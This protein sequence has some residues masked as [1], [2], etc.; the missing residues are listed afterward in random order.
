[1]CVSMFDSLRKTIDCEFAHH[2]QPMKFLN[3]E[4]NKKITDLL[5]AFQQRI[6]ANSKFKFEFKFKF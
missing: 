5:S 4:G 6:K 2:F 1:M 3:I